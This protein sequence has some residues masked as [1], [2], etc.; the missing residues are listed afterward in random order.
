MSPVEIAGRPGR[1]DPVPSPWDS[2]LLATFTVSPLIPN[3]NLWVPMTP[4][5]LPPGC[6]PDPEPEVPPVAGACRAAGLDHCQAQIDDAR[7]VI[8]PAARASP[9]RGHVGIADR[10]DLLL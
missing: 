9:P 10:L 2:S 1:G 3:A 8:G 5:T 4:P 6:I 7:G